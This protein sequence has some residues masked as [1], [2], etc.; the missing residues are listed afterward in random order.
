MS[1]VR[2]L[3]DILLELKDKKHS[4]GNSAELVEK[5]LDLVDEANDE[6]QDLDNT[7]EQMSGLLTAYERGG[8][9]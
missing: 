6:A 3:L 7:L 9:A 1:K 8:A 4:F 5:A 2:E